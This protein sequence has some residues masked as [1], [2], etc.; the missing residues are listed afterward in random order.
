MFFSDLAQALGLSGLMKLHDSFAEEGL[1][2][3]VYADLRQRLVTGRMCPGHE[4]STRSL[5]AELGVSQTPV[6]DA[7]SRLAAEGAVSIRSKRRVRV[8]PMTQERFEDLLHCRLLLEPDAA[9]NALPFLGEAQVARLRSAD[10][11]LDAAIAAG[12]ADAYMRA[13]HDFHFTLYRAQGGP[14]L[15]QLI[16][17]LWLQFGPFMRV[18]YGRVSNISLNDYHQAA[19][20][21]IMDG[22]ATALRTAIADDIA[23]GMGLIARTGLAPEGRAAAV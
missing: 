2:A 12:D 17:T 14:T 16:E 19:I 18:A 3:A 7:L 20:R 23:D 10:A 8:P 11:A 1:N 21:A 4:L 15:T 6:R 5:A 22:D 9:A 13:N